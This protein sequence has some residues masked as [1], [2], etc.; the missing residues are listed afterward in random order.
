MGEYTVHD[1]PYRGKCI[2]TMIVFIPPTKTHAAQIKK[3]GYPLTV[4]VRRQPRFSR[5][6]AVSRPMRGNC[7]IK[8]EF[9]CIFCQN[10]IHCSCRWWVLLFVYFLVYESSNSLV[11]QLVGWDA[12]R[13]LRLLGDFCSLP[14]NVLHA[15]MG[16]F[17]LWHRSKGVC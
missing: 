6:P 16:C 9:L 5:S 15:L 10:L 14:Q 13:L 17:L 11:G 3:C 7:W 4:K 8:F 2:P 1:Q 12:S